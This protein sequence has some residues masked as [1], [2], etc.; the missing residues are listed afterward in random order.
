MAYGQDV[1]AKRTPDLVINKWYKTTDYHVDHGG[2]LD[3]YDVG[4]SLGAGSS[5]PYVNDS[6]YYSKNFRTYKVLDNGPIRSTFEL[7]YDA[8]NVNG[9]SVTESKIISLDAGSQL[10]KMQTE[11][12]F[13]NKKELPVAIGIVKR[14]ENGSMLLDEKNGIM[15]YWEPQ[16]GKD[17][18][19]GIGALMEEPVLNMQVKDHHLL[20]I[21]NV[22]SKKPFVYYTGAAWDKAGLITNSKEWFNYLQN[23]KE[24]IQRPVI[25]KWG[26]G[27]GL[28]N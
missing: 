8:W 22:E 17:G 12:P 7:G 1:W 25:V 6:I 28:K 13:K 23:F 27:E 10:S 5:D 14:K 15:G 24:K 18:T 3:F 20:T 11:Y 19:L 21:I 2:G 26:I 9:T 16:H 4:F